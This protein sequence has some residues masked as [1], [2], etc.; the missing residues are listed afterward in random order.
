MMRNRAIKTLSAAAIGVAGS[1]LLFVFFI[2]VEALVLYLNETAD[3]ALSPLRIIICYGVVVAY[4]V[5]L[6]AYRHVGKP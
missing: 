1:L 2:L 6:E 4:L 5:G 3:A